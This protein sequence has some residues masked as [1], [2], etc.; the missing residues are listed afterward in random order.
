[1]ASPQNFRSAFNGFNREDV[2]RYLEYINARHQSQT[3]QLS[4]EVNEL[5]ARLA[6]RESTPAEPQ[7]QEAYDALKEQYEALQSRFAA[8]EERC[9]CL[10]VQLEQKNLPSLHQEQR[11]LEAYRQAERIQQ[12]A[13]DRAE[14]VYFQA[15][16]VLSEAAARVDGACGDITG[17]TDQVMSQI[18]QLQ[19]AISA[20]KQAL[21]EASSIMR[22]IRPNR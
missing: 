4:E 19:V 15:N 10:N 22:T 7:L 17:L 12:E 2:V 16:T 5:R 21:Q 3:N 8:L 13:K 20:S 6:E 11:E 18:T 9:A 1:M 14:L